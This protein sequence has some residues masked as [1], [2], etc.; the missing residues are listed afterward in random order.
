MRLIA[1]ALALAVPSTGCSF[2]LTH[3]PSDAAPRTAASPYPPAC[4]NSMAWPAVDGVIAG[5]VILGLISAI[6]NDKPNVATD[7]VSGDAVTSALIVAGTAAASGIV[8][9]QRVSKCRRAE[10]GYAA[11]YPYGGQP[12][13]YA[14]PAAQYPTPPYAA[15]PYPTQP[16]PGP[17]P[18][19]PA[20]TTQAQ[21]YVPP[22]VPPVAPAP[23]FPPPPVGPPPPVKTPAKPAPDA[24]LG[25]EGDVCTTQ[26]ECSTGLLC[27]SNVCLRPKK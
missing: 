16:Y 14:Q 15:Q 8:G 25:T 2:F 9:Y 5:I 6:S 4:T 18:A 13:P 10:E 23:P 1:L 21:T 20:A 17:P 11:M 19:T 26:A 24:T 22:P 3:G 27:T 7:N 12:Y